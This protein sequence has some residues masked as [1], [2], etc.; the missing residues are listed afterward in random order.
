[1]QPKIYTSNQHGIDPTLI[2][3]DALFV[4]EKLRNAGFI[5]YLVGGSVRDLLINKRPKDFDISTSARPEQ[6]K[7]LF[8]RKCIL[9]G[10]RFRLAHIRFGHK[11][12][13]VATFRRGDNDDELIIRDNEWG[14]P[15]EDVLRRDFTMNGLF[16]DS[17]NHTIID[18]VG[19]S[20]DI[21]KGIIRTIGEAEVRFRQD[22][23]RMLRLLKFQARFDFTIDLKTNEALTSCAQE[24][25]KSSQARLLEELFRMLESGSS[26]AFFELLATRGFLALLLPNLM[27]VLYTQEGKK[28]FHY[29]HC[30]DEIYRHKGQNTLDRSTLSACFIFPVLDHVIQEYILQHKAIPHIGEISVIASSL[31]KE[32]LVHEMSHFPRRI[33]SLIISILVSQY[34]IT[35]LLK[36]KHIPERTI[37]HKDFQLALKFLKIRALVDENLVDTYQSVRNQYQSLKTHPHHKSSPPSHSKKLSHPR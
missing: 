6:V 28:I 33:A 14:T 18:Y 10:R 8:Q 9:I 2:D 30:V 27:R 3:S 13:E 4:L 7:A 26:A 23:V 12:I 37:R 1:M 19:G 34:R 36:K 5:A 21:Q 16:Y 29:L 24:I 35:P 32:L 25:L 31:V 11:I 20:E 15:E 17:S 22:P